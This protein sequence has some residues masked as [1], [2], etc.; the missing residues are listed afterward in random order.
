VGD[1]PALADP[2][3][4][5]D[6][7]WIPLGAG[8]HGFVRWNGRM[9]EAIKARAERRP[10]LDLYHTALEV[11]LPDGRFTIESAWPSP[12]LDTNSRGVM[13]EGPVFTSRLE[14]FRAFR[15]EVRCWRDGVIPDAGEAVA[16]AQPVATDPAAA[17]ALLGLVAE[18]PPLAWGRDPPG[19]GDM[20]NSNSVIS[21][22]LARS[23]LPV[24]DL[25]PP[26]GGHA[27]GW[28]AG[29]ALAGR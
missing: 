20:W 3:T 9:Y 5:I 12:D 22:L 29:V 28:R 21:W 10:R 17:R 6:L 23:G 4:C 7:F 19:V 11:H 25:R 15:Y 13:V 26:A 24:A 18:V 2:G 27:P 16:G 1:Q 8:G 14:R